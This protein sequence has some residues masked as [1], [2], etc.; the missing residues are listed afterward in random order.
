MLISSEKHGLPPVKLITTRHSRVICATTPFTPSNTP[1][2]THHR[3]AHLLAQ[4]AS[5]RQPQANPVEFRVLTVCAD[6]L[7]SRC[8]TPGVETTA[9]RCCSV[10]R[11]N[12]Y[13]LNSGRST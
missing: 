12:T 11:V 7:P 10:N 3:N 5:A 2:C 9:S 1:P 6:D 8:S 13:P 4:H